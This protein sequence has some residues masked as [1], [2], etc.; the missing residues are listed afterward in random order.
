[1][2]VDLPKDVMLTCD[3]GPDFRVYRFQCV[4]A[5]GSDD[6]RMMLYMGGHPS[7][8][9][10]QP[11]RETG[12]PPAVTSEKSTFLGEK[13]DWRSWKVK[14]RTFK[15]AIASLG[16]YN[17]V[18]VNFSAVTAEDMKMLEK[19]AQDMK[20]VP[21]VDEKPATRQAEPKGK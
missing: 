12:K 19:I 21:H 11:Q 18:H 20:L 1:V 17:K 7:F 5:F 10:N 4:R 15:E 16:E 6:T 13:V 3:E 9:S 2:L 14:E 8:L